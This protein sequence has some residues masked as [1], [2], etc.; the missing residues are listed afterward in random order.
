MPAATGDEHR[1]HNLADFLELCSL[2]P[3]VL[4]G[5]GPGALIVAVPAEQHQRAA[6]ITQTFFWTTTAT[7]L[8]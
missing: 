5:N 2:E 4:T 7:S 6:D 1:A 8:R 3:Q